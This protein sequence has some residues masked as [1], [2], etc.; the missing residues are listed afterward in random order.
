M[1]FQDYVAETEEN[2]REALREYQRRDLDE[3]EKIFD[4]LWTD[5][6][7]TG[8][9]SG[10]YTF[11]AYKA[12]SNVSDLIFDGEFLRD[13]KEIGIDPGALLKEGPE[14]VDVTARC[15]A[16]GRVDI[17]RLCESERER[18]D[19]ARRTC[20]RRPRAAAVRDRSEAR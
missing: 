3:P 4:E 1:T 2:V 7:V 9:G 19:E 13:L 12:Q 17:D 20:A 5:D 8:N 11:N 18:R 16:L 15:L 14:A 6:A 10:S